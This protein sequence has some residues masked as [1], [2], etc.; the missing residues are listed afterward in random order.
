MV[1]FY[2]NSRF[3]ISINAIPGY[4]YGIEILIQNLNSKV[5]VYN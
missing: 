5:I 2:V 3:F 1:L 4:K